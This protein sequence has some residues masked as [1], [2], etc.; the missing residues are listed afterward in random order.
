MQ[1]MWQRLVNGAYTHDVLGAMLVLIGYWNSTPTKLVFK[2]SIPFALPTWKPS[3]VTPVC[4][5]SLAKTN[6]LMPLGC[7]HIWLTPTI[8]YKYQLE[9]LKTKKNCLKY[10]TLRLQTPP[11][12]QSC[13]FKAPYW[14]QPIRNMKDIDLV[15]LKMGDLKFCRQLGP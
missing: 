15:D 7:V 13:F 9:N 11:L 12:S 10:L 2:H 14:E 8:F 3:L 5:L 6:E 4:S 1:D